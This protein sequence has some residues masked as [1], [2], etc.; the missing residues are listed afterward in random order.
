MG[1]S[2]HVNLTLTTARVRDE[3]GLSHEVF[4][5]LTMPFGRTVASASAGRDAV[6]RR[7]G[8]DVMRALPVG[9]GY[10]Y[11]LRTE[12]GAR[13]MVAAVAQMQNRYGRYEVRQETF[14]GRQQVR[15]QAAGALVAIGGG[16]FASRPLRS[17]FALV[18]VPQVEGVRGFASNQEVGRTN[19]DGNLLIP[20]LEAYY[21]NI[22]RIADEDVPLSYS[23]GS[24]RLTLAPPFRGGAVARFPVKATRRITGSVRIVTAA[25]ERVPAHGR[26]TIRVD[27]RLEISPVGNDGEFYFEDLPG[28]RLPATIED[29]H[30][31]CDFVLL[32]P[33]VDTLAADLG[34]TR[35]TTKGAP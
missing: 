16:V 15:L 11:Q 23:V 25:G 21:G 8:V 24:T 5:G 19:A 30:G 17:S 27:S 4:A 1:I 18:Q 12:D 32:I 22:L 35:C 31:T 28:G 14:D 10:G 34:T 26:L 2:R 29:E 6:G 9:E 7:A 33:A 20:D 13:N 3:G